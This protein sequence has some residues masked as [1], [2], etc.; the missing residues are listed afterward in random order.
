M[1]SGDITK[2]PWTDSQTEAACREELAVEARIYQRLGAHPRLVAVKDWDPIKHVLTLEYMPHGNLRKYVMEH[3]HE[4][5]ITR[6]LQWAIEAAESIE[7]LHSHDIIQA[8]VGAHN[9]LL[10][11]ELSLRICDFGGSSIDGSEAL[12]A[13]GSRYMLPRPVGVRLVPPTKTSDLFALGSLLYLIA[14]G[15]ESYHDLEDEDEVENRYR[16]GCF[17]N[18]EGVIFAEIIR[19]CWRQEVESAQKVTELLRHAAIEAL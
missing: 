12:V 16:D 4:I 10:D 9:F 6:K 15:H 3:G 19:K 13:P 1:D 5:S 2:S 7:L 11:S 8:D 17:P 14:T 18:L